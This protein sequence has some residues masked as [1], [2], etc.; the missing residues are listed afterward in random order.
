MN[1]IILGYLECE[2]DKNNLTSIAFASAAS[3]AM[4]SFITSA[5]F[6]IGLLGR[7]GLAAGRR[8]RT[9]TWRSCSCWRRN[10]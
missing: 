7:A 10:L 2:G 8:T 6:S 9:I 3:S 4:A 1:Q 5:F